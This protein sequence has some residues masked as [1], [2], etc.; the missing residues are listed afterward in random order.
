M[1]Q[2]SGGFLELEFSHWKLEVELRL[3]E[4]TR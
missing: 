3:D 1:L 2:S 4:W